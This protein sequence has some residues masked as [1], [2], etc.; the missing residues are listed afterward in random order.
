MFLKVLKII[1]VVLTALLF[2]AA[3]YLW[4]PDKSKAELEKVYGS[5]KTAYVSALGVN[6]HYQDTG[7]SKNPVPILFLHGF[8]SSL[9]TWD[10]WTEALSSEYRVISLDLPGFALTGEDPSG[11][12]TDERSVAVIE[13]FL[14]ELQI[15]KVV[16]V[17]NS[18]GGKFAWQFAAR[19]PDQVSKLV[20]ISPDGY[21]SPRMEYGKKTE[22]P[23]IAQLYRY[24]FSKTFLAMNLEPAYANPN[25]LNDALV[26]RYY[27]LMLA[28]GVRG[29]ILARMQQTV[30]Q[31]PVPA[32]T[33]I[34]VPTLLI[35]GEKDAFI[36]I[37]NANDYLKVMPNAKRVSL[38]NI[39][40]L[41]QEEQPNIGLAALK[42][43][44]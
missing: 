27:D 13:A 37:A 7:P 34:K 42:E 17:G 11:I 28:P 20:L 31:D 9:Q 14:K 35:W 18:M 8:G 23:A 43:F 2:L 33:N 22:V 4:T 30:L 36:P 15:P 24:F 1:A 39:G 44:L 6:I 12:Y 29:A 26:N 19:Y 32:L 41:P 16:L 38:P 3:L 10:A 25:T 5:P 21:A 40:H